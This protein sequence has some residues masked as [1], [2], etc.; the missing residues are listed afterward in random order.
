MRCWLRN[1]CN[2]LSSQY[3]L[4]LFLG[5]KKSRRAT[6]PETTRSILLQCFQAAGIWTCIYL[7][8]KVH[9]INWT[10]WDVRYFTVKEFI[11]YFQQKCLKQYRYTYSDACS[12]S[13]PI[14]SVGLTQIFEKRRTPGITYHKTMIFWSRFDF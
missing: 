2:K 14:F 3:L 13:L 11:H 9:Q 7:V 8:V 1:Y 6:R 4:T 5:G 12:A 10:C